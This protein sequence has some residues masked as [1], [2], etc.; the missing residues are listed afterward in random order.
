[1]LGK[2]NISQEKLQGLIAYTER[3]FKRLTTL[4]TNVQ[5]LRYTINS[6]T[7]HGTN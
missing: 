3:H 5:F 2:L 4:L 1:M 7:P 6:A